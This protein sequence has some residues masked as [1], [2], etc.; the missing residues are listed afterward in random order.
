MTQRNAF[1]LALLA[2]VPLL[3]PFSRAAELPI[4]L[5][6][7]TGIYALAR[8]HR[9]LWNDSVSRALGLALGLY[10]LA[11]LIS[12]IDAIDAEKSWTTAIASLRLLLYAIG[13]RWLL[14]E[15]PVH[16]RW[17]SLAAALPVAAW[18]L[19]GTAQALT[20]YSIGGP[21]DADRLSGIFGADDL[22][23]G[24]LL[25]A[26]APLLLWPLFD[27]CLAA[28]S[29]KTVAFLLGA[30]LLLTLVVLLAGSRAGWISFALVSGLLGLRV[31][32]RSPRLALGIA[33]VTITVVA[34]IGSVAYQQSEH[35]RARV[36]RTLE[37]R[38]GNADHALAGRLPIWRTAG[39]MIAAHPLNG[40]GVRSF[41]FA[42][43]DFAAAD[44]PWV[45]PSGTHGAAHAHQILLELLSETGVVGLCC[46]LLAGWWLWRLRRGALP[47]AAAALLVLTFPL[48]THLAFYSSFMG[49]VL[50]W[51][52]ALMGVREGPR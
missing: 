3:L 38:T 40:V 29:I 36:D 8:D 14:L 4:L 25:P 16:Y 10:S 32:E 15:A 51:L 48:N 41:R 12:A 47:G 39:A 28:P 23:L 44:D 6:A 20:G 42:Y 26:L 50:A 52:V 21:L 19:D 45:D 18:V 30:Y 17:V 33:A 1:A 27:R 34:L 2:L 24:P 43:P 31:I 7:L 49:I 11:A 13:V 9:R 37:F 5:G 35:F 46:W 22:K